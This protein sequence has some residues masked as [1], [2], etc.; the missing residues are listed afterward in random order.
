MQDG[1]ERII[2]KFCGCGAGAN[3]TLK[4]L[5]GAGQHFSRGGLIWADAFMRLYGQGWDVT[6]GHER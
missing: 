4:V 2:Q 5:V 6:G 1:C 3:S